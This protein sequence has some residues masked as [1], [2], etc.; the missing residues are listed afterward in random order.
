MSLRRGRSSS[1][2]TCIASTP[3]PAH[4]RRRPNQ[5]L[6]ERLARCEQLLKNYVDGA[7]ASAQGKGAQPPSVPAGKDREPEAEPEPGPPFSETTGEGNS[8]LRAP[9]KIIE[10]GGTVRFLDNFLW[11]SFHDELQAIKDIVTTGDELEPSSIGTEDLSPENNSDLFLVSDNMTSVQD[12]QPDPAHVFRLWQLFLD[13]VNPLTKVV[14]VPTLQP[15]VM[16]AAAN[17]GNVPVAY[18]ALLFAVYGMAVFSL[19]DDECHR[20]LDTSRENAL[21]RF[22]KGTKLSLVRLNFLKNH[23]MTSLQALVLF[24]SSLQG[25]ND[26]HAGWILSGTIVRI[27][28]KM[29]YHRDGTHLGLSPFET[30]LRRRLWW[31]IVTQDAQHAIASGSNHML[32]QNWDTRMPQNV[33]DAD[34]FPSSMEP[35]QAREGPTEMAFCVLM[36]MFVKFAQLSNTAMENALIGMRI[37]N[38]TEPTAAQQQAISEFKALIDKLERD[39]VDF[40]QK[41]VDLKAGGVYVAAM[42]V[43]PMVIRKLKAIMTPMREQPEWGTEIL[44]PKDSLFKAFLTACEDKA[45]AYEAGSAHGFGWYYMQYFQVEGFG[46]MAAQLAQRPTGRLADRGWNVIEKVYKYQPVLFDMSQKPYAAQARITLKAWKARE[47]ALAQSGQYIDLPECVRRLSEAIQYASDSGSSAKASISPPE[48]SQ[49]PQ[50]VTDIDLLISQSMDMPTMSW[51]ML[52]PMWSDMGMDNE[53]QESAM[54]FEGM[55]FGDMGQMGNMG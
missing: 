21:Q 37:Q 47:Q 23:D 40:E 19:S 12:L 13:R 14:H 43:R 4:K 45:G 51:D 22:N 55:D 54:E 17:V 30:E 8:N 2:A 26:P 34:L 15:Y 25:R 50:E 52:G 49:M 46:V 6:R 18:Q 53:N 31:Y 1:R 16:E 20:M 10:E 36:Y 48:A 11:T 42:T 24:L 7:A 32:S 38:R 29:G 5:D 33:N 41:K 27:A 3:A 44:R 9:G 39:M 35:V 28:Q